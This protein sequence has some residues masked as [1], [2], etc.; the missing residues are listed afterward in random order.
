MKEPTTEFAKSRQ[1]QI[2]I[3]RKFL[4]DR[5]WELKAEYP[6]SETFVHRHSELI[7]CSIGLHGAFSIAELHWINKTPENQFSSLNPN[8]TEEDYISILKMLN[9]KLQ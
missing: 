3:N 7:V 1:K 5:G 8:L 9:L 2:T 6:L 4:L